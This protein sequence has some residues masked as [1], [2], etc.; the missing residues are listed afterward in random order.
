MKVCETCTWPGLHVQQ[1]AVA[2]TM[3]PQ[4]DTSL[5]F[6]G[7]EEITERCSRPTYSRRHGLYH[8]IGDY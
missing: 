8:G 5:S 2:K 6:P 7:F 4:K 3:Q 1:Q